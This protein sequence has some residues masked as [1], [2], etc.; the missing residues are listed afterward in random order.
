MS[1]GKSHT[2]ALFGLGGTPVQVE[3]DISSNLPSFVLVGLPDASLSEATARVRSACSNSGLALPARKITVNLSP[4]SVP[5]QGSSFDLSIA[6]A[7]L[8]AT[9]MLNASSVKR[10]AH[11]G[12]LG[13]DGSVRAV[14]GVLPMVLA[15]KKAGFRRAV[16]PADNEAEARLVDG[17]EV[18]AA[19]HLMQ[20][21]AL[22]GADV[23]AVP[24]SR[25]LNVAED[26]HQPEFKCM[27][28]VVGQDEAIEAM[29]IAAAGR[30]HMLMIGPPG[31]GKT[32]LAERMPTILPMLQPDEALELASIRSL[33]VLEP[34]SRLPQQ[35]SFEAPH[36]SCSMPALIGGGVGVPKPGLISLAHNGVLFL[37]EA[38]EFTSQALESLRQPLESGQININ[39]ASGSAWFPARFQLILAANPCQCGHWLTNPAKCSCTPSSRA[40][41]LGKLSGPLRDRIDLQLTLYPATRATLS[42]SSSASQTS[43]QIRARVEQA[44][45]ISRKRLIETPWKANSEISGAYLRKHL[46]P[47]A[48]ATAPLDEAVTRGLISMRAYDRCLR[49]AWTICDLNQRNQV[50][51]DDV[52]RALSLRGH[53]QLGAAA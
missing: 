39:R 42:G 26:S 49:V 40:R 16:V 37:D 19:D 1:L 18:L 13:L 5:K 2:I 47:P 52:L 10:F 11:F 35:P 51:R 8:A 7:V 12:E 44:R 3:A 6:V 25:Q 22:H 46:R 53:T 21:A 45:E 4:A 32:M 24:S 43:E 31:A 34:I 30:H 48:S 38:P 28:E 36:H 15:A 33:S 9:G 14:K 27:S 29:T 23:P 17:I 20:V 50:S 41:Y